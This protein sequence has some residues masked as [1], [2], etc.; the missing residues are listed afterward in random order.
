MPGGTYERGLPLAVVLVGFAL[1]MFVIFLRYLRERYVNA[2]QSDWEDYEWKSPQ[3]RRQDLRWRRSAR[4][5]SQSG[6]R[7]LS[8][9]SGSGPGKPK[10][11][12][13]SERRQN[14]LRVAQ[15][16]RDSS[17]IRA[18][19]RLQRKRPVSGEATAPTDKDRE[20][21]LKHSSA[22]KDGRRQLSRAAERR[23]AEL[24]IKQ[25]MQ[26]ARE[27]DFSAKGRSESISERKKRARL[28]RRRDRFWRENRS[29][30]M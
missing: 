1:G 4:A 5:R 23:Q 16:R 24:R 7:V 14:E 25:G 6:S 11:G 2:R 13:S 15:G 22:P 29:F 17:R 27:A 26:Y 28:R 12:H 10:I 21:I 30:W 20:P 18:T 8:A 3:A 9:G 19:G